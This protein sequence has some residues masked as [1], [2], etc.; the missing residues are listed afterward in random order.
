MQQRFTLVLLFYGLTLAIA[1]GAGIFYV[2]N[3]YKSAT[4]GSAIVQAAGD[5]NGRCV[6]TVFKR[7]YDVTALRSTHTGGDIFK[8]GTDMSAAYQKQHGSST[9]MIEKY[10]IK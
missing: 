5:G 7:Q 10:L 8:C 3:F 2:R 1:I 9:K 4:D 6:V